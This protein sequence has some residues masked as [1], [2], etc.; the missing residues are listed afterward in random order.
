MTHEEVKL[1]LQKVDEIKEIQEAGGS[2]NTNLSKYEGLI[3]YLLVRYQ[4]GRRAVKLAV[5]VDKLLNVEF[6]EV[7]YRPSIPMWTESVFS[8][9]GS[10]GLQSRIKTVED[11]M[12]ALNDSSIRTVGIWGQGGVGKTTIVKAIAKKALEMKL[13]KVVMATVTRNPQIRNI[14]GQI[15]DM[16]GMTLEEETEIGRAGQL[17]ERL[18]K[19]KEN[20]LVILDDLWD[21]LDLNNFGIPIHDD[22]SSQ[23]TMRNDSDFPASEIAKKCG[24]LLGALVTIG[25]TLKNK[26]SST[27]TDVLQKLE[28][29]EFTTEEESME[30][31]TKL[32]YDHLENERLKA[33]FLLCAQMGHNSLI[34]DL[35][36]YCIGLSI[37]EGVTTIREAQLKLDMLIK[38][39]KDASLLLDS[40]SSD[41][42]TMHDIVRDAA[43]SIAFK[44][45]A[46]LYKKQVQLDDEWLDMDKVEKYTAISLHYCD[47]V[48]GLPK[49]INF[50]RLKIFCVENNN[51]SLRISDKFFEGMTE[52]RVLLLID[53]KRNASLAEL[54]Q[55]HQLKA[56]DVHIPDLD[57]FPKNAFFQ[58]LDYYMITVGDFKMFSV[59]GFKMP[60]QY[61]ASRTLALHLKEG[62]NNVHSQ[63]GIKLLFNTVEKLFLGNL[64]RVGNIFYELNLQGFPWLKHLY[65]AN[66]NDIKYIINSMNLLSCK[67]RLRKLFIWR[68]ENLKHVWSRDPEGIL[69]FKSLQDVDVNRCDKIDNLFPF[70]VANGLKQLESLAIRYCGGME[71]IVGRE[72]GSNAKGVK[73]EFPNLTSVSFEE[74]RKKEVYLL[75]RSIDNYYLNSLEALSLE[76][77]NNPEFL[78]RLLHRTPN[79]EKLNLR[80]CDFRELLRPGTLTAM[81]KIGIVVQLK[82]FSL[83]LMNSLHDIGFKQDPSLFQQLQRLTVSYSNHLINLALGTVCFSHLTCLN[84]WYC[85]RLINLMESFTAKSLSQ[86]TTLKISSCHAMEEIVSKKERKDEREDKIAFHR[87]TTLKLSNLWKLTSFCSSEC[88]SFMFPVLERLVVTYCP[89]MII[90][91]QGGLEEPKLRKVYF[92]EEEEGKWYWRDNLNKTIRDRFMIYIERLELSDYLEQLWHGKDPIPEKCF[93]NLEYLSVVNCEFLS[94][95]I[96]CHLL[97]YLKNVKEL[98][99]RSCNSV[100]TV[101]DISEIK[102]GEIHLERMTLEN[103]PNLKNVWNLVEN[104]QGIFSI[105]SLETVRITSC[106]S[107]NFLFPASLAENLEKLQNLSIENCE[108]MEEIVGKDETAAEGEF[109]KFKFPCLTK[110]TLKGLFKLECFYPGK[111]NLECPKLESLVVVHCAS[112]LY[113]LYHEVILKQEHLTLNAKD[114]MMLYCGEFQENL[115]NIKWL[116]LQCFHN[117]N[118]GDTLPYGFLN[119][120]PNIEALEVFCSGFNMIFPA[121]RLEVDDNRI[122]TQLRKLYLEMLPGLKSIGLE[123]YWIDPLCS[124]LKALDV[125]CC[126]LLTTLVQSTVSFYNLKRL[127]IVSCHGL[128]YLFTSST[129]KSLVQLEEMS[130]NSSKSIKGIVAKEE[131]DSCFNEIIFENLRKLKL[132]SLSSLLS[133]CTGNTTL[134]FP[135]LETVYIYECPRMEIFF[136]GIINA[137]K[138]DQIRVLY[139]AN[140]DF[141]WD[142]DLNTTIMKLLNEKV[143]LEQCKYLKLSDY[144]EAEK[145]WHG[146]VPLPKACFRRL[147]TLVVENCDFL[148]N[149]I[150]SHLLL[151]LKKLQV[152]NCIYAEVIFDLNDMNMT[153]NEKV[154]FSL[155][156]LTL[157]QLPNLKHVWSKDPEGISFIN[158]KLVQVTNCEGLKALFTTSLPKI[159][160]KLEKLTVESCETKE[161]IVGKDKAAAESSTT[162]FVFPWLT[163]LVLSKNPNLKYFYAG[164]HNLVCTNLKYLRVYHYGKFGMFT[165][166]SQNYQEGQ[167]EDHQGGISVNAVFFL[168]SKDTLPFGFLLKVPNMETLAIACSEFKEIF[169]SQRLEDEHI[170]KLA[171]LKGLRLVNLSQPSSIGL[172]HSWQDQLCENLEVLQIRRCPRLTNIV[173]SAMSFSSLKK[174]FINQC[175]GL[176]CLF[177][178]STAKSLGRLKEMCIEECGSIKEIVAKEKDESNQD[179][180][181]FEKLMKLSL[182]S[183]PCLTSFHTGNSSLK[184]PSLHKVIITQCPKMKIFSQGSIY[185]PVLIGIQ[186]SQDEH[187]VYDEYDRVQLV[188]YDLHWNNNL[189]ST[190][191]QLFHE[192]DALFSKEKLI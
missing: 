101:F 150:P 89:E 1:W 160:E 81:E 171:Q 122:L 95:V 158:L 37:I 72:N 44:E 151:Y 129:A 179:E 105:P 139:W 78:F 69:N 9:I 62:N 127:R 120:I 110:L 111:H 64:N 45:G 98:I 36:K 102:S 162:K 8:G 192:K 79:L 146:K 189:N 5:D 113:S 85:D 25:K 67:G 75:S 55:L 74:L 138:L 16:L 177:T 21:G 28:R 59:E 15:A 63:K 135:S 39:L 53:E 153:T 190:I 184:L 71:Q 23:K 126:N 178:S 125:R 87:L 191:E 48:D 56:L 11:I 144:P 187:V 65:I 131:D 58:A 186:V 29:H 6:G 80:N 14:Q 54:S 137:P 30:F 108:E 132:L 152:K 61:E 68:L 149:V 41:H 31:T 103:L 161:E 4:Q 24:G 167:A 115:H 52:L 147:Q 92:G 116:T 124:N 90:F 49:S 140:N 35:L 156:I 106:E 141:H 27:G 17:R 183:L 84:V 174:L 57:V 136:K 99:V 86:L 121:Q 165:L 46:S 10:E 40:Y 119:N 26:N 180:I 118:E 60:D 185:T 76:G 33:T 130:I 18:K 172:E 82:D 32:S 94:I 51:H 93:T 142:T 13:F 107:L 104:S 114:T 175:H 7:S 97:F 42:F 50:P 163:L 148:S 181:I 77:L 176:E 19:D 164:R 128:E 3:P 112:T 109:H 70:S 96:P 133:F 173:Q 159:L 145:V 168:N 182:N 66:N 91:T 155:E 157:D 188:D 123:H 100:Q 134:N 2:A 12:T 88:C 73:F 143:Y 170:R 154:S 166:N 83:Q 117:V 38:R 20:T 47:I 43:L 22:D 169:P 34:V